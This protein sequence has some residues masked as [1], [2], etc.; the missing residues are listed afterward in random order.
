MELFSVNQL[1]FLFASLI[2]NLAVLLFLIVFY[3][4]RV[5]T[6]SSDCIRDCLVILFIKF[7][8]ILQQAMNNLKDLEQNSF[9]SANMSD[10]HYKTAVESL[11]RLGISGTSYEENFLCTTTGSSEESYQEPINL[12]IHKGKLPF[13]RTAS[14]PMTSTPINRLKELLEDPSTKCTSMVEKFSKVTLDESIMETYKQGLEMT[15]RSEVRRVKKREHPT[16]FS[17]DN[18]LAIRATVSKGFLPESN[19]NE[20]KLYYQSTAPKRSI[21]RIGLRL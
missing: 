21:K 10:N 13:R 8:Y 7:A 19:K 4:L 1:A 17:K 12:V 18:A 20:L 16:L 5:I 15:N 2:I 6:E 9:D 11:S 3:I 14:A